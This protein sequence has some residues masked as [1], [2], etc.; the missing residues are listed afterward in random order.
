MPGEGAR[1]ALLR[2]IESWNGGDLNA[3]MDLY[4]ESHGLLSP[5]SANLVGTLLHHLV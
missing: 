1:A 3:Y 2:A 4:A 5:G